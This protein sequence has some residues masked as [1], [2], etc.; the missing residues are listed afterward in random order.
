MS[1]LSEGQPLTY[2]YLSQ[3]E[4]ELDELK[5]T[6]AGLVG[7]TKGIDDLQNVYVRIDNKGGLRNATQPSNVM[8]IAGTRVLTFAG[9]SSKS[10]YDEVQFDVGFSTIPIVVATIQDP[11]AAGKKVS[12]SDIAFATVTIGDINKNKFFY[13]VELIK[14]TGNI[15]SGDLKV[16]YFAIGAK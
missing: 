9:G 1:R 6:V 10:I 11:T 16:N 5:G 14:S 12:S 15:A 13:K 3:I 2:D 7:V 4:K 8:T